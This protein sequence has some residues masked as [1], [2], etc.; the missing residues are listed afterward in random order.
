MRVPSTEDVLPIFQRLYA[1]CMEHDLPIGLAPNVHVS[2]VMLPDECRWL[3]D[4]PNRYRFAEMK[5]K[6]MRRVFA[7]RLE[8]E[9]R[10]ARAS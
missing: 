1:A 4:D 2:L 9:L 8:R 3:Q 10:A 6:V 5:R 7:S